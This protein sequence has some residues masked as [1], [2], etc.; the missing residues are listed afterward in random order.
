M[1]SP[2]AL[3]SDVH[4]NSLALKAVLED[5]RELGC[6]QVFMLGDLINGVDPHGCVQFLRQWQE[7]AHVELTC[8][9]GNGEA[10]LLTPDRAALPRQTEA[11]NADMIQLV[12]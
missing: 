6:T 10:Y 4:G 8:L 7:A 11:W 12:D 3:L 9:K 5:I 2:V 1:S